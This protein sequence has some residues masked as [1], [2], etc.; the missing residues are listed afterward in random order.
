MF[1]VLVSLNVNTILIQSKHLSIT[2]LYNFLLHIEKFGE[3]SNQFHPLN[4]NRD[5]NQAHL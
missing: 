3:K 5:L 2:A 4:L 1:Q